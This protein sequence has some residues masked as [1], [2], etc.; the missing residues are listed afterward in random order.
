MEMGVS[1][2]AASTVRVR[3][4][5]INHLQSLTGAAKRPLTVEECR[6]FAVKNTVSL[7]WRIGRAVDFARKQYAI[8]KVG[9][10]IIDAVGGDQTAKLLFAGKVVEVSRK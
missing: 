8:G 9:Q 6:R 10:V 4:T 5:N 7:A 3:Y 1:L 2:P